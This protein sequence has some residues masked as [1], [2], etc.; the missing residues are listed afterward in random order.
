MSVHTVCTD[1]L[2]Q[3]GLTLSRN[4]GGW[5]FRSRRKVRVIGW[6]DRKVIDGGGGGGEGEEK[7]KI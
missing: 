5:W 4:L 6:V 7:K 3:I 1:C 2:L